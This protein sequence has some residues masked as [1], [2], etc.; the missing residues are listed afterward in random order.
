MASFEIQEERPSVPFV[1]TDE[2]GNVIFRD[3]ITFKNIVELRNASLFE[4]KVMMNERYAQHL[5]VLETMRLAPILEPEAED[6][7]VEE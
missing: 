4:R 2:D 7:P 5:A 3:A 6:P 1:I